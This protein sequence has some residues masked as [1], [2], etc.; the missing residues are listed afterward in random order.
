MAQFAGVQQ[1]VARA[2]SLL[3][4]FFVHAHLAQHRR[5]YGAH[6]RLAVLRAWTLLPADQVRAA[7]D[8][9]VSDMRRDRLDVQRVRIATPTAQCDSWRQP[10]AE[11]HYVEFRFACA[12]STTRN[13]HWLAKQCVPHGAHLV[14]ERDGDAA[15]DSERTVATLRCYAQSMCDAHAALERLLYALRSADIQISW[16]AIDT[17]YVLYDSRVSLDRDWLYAGQPAQARVRCRDVYVS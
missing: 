5:D 13:A 12:L 8:R 9:V 7:A 2:D 17:L 3:R 6:R 15:A 1:Y 10:I 11:P 16:D 4:H 14:T